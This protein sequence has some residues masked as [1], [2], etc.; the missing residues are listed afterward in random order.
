METLSFDVLLPAFLLTLFAGLSTGI[1]AALAFFSKHNNTKVLSIGLGFSAGVMI[2]IS[3]AE[4]MQKSKEAFL[5]AFGDIGS[6]VIMLLCL[7][8]G[9]GITFLIDQFIPEEINPHELRKEQELD[10][11]KED[12][13]QP[14]RHML[15]H[16]TGIFTAIAIG[17]HN[18]PEGFAT[19]VA[20]IEE[21][22]LGIAIALAI[23]IHNIPEGMAVSLPI[24]H[25]TGDR[26]RAFFY[27]LSSGLAEP[28]G[29]I[30]GFFL[31]MPLM[32]D[33]TLGIT[34]GIVAGIMLYISFD[35]LLPSARVYGNAH[36]TILGI[37]LGMAV[38]A[39]SLV[40]FKLA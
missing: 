33:M 13:S 4:I 2:Y 7:F 35:E 32:G 36:T 12:S 10:E 15:L 22:S 8:L 20:A 5:P 3:F 29:A 6:D 25:A 30:I 31:L 27:A 37:A 24:Y 26:K 21:L 11:L 28:V 16:R 34:F 39:F 38:M 9:F 18:F 17:I 1:G 23:A 19:F 14:K 40:A